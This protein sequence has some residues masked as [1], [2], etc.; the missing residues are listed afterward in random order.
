VLGITQQM[1]GVGT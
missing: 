1:G